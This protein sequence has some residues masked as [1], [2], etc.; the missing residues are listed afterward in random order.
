MGHDDDEVKIREAEVEH[1]DGGDEEED[2]GEHEGAQH[3]FLVGVFGGD[4]SLPGVTTAEGT[5][6][7]TL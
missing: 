5:F 2:E 4:R 6:L 1:E 3:D 7:M